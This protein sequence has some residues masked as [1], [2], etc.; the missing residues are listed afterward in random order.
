MA[1]AW[2]SGGSLPVG[3]DDAAGCGVWNAA[4]Q[5][6]GSP[7][8]GT[9][10]VH[11]YDGA[12]WSAKTTMSTMRSSNG[13]CGTTSAAWAFA[14]VYTG[15]FQTSTENFNGTSWSS[16]GS[17]GTATA[18][19]AACGTQTAG[20][21]V[22]GAISGTYTDVT[23]HYNGSTTSTGGTYPQALC[24]VATAG[25]QTAAFATGGVDYSGTRK[26][27]CYTYNGTSWSSSTSLT[28]GRYEHSASGTATGCLAACGIETSSAVSSAL[29][30]NGGSWS[31][32]GNVSTARYKHA[33]AGGTADSSL[34]FG[35]TNGSY[36]SSTEEYNDK[37][38]GAF[39]FE[40]VVD[41]PTVGTSATSNIVTPTDTTVGAAWSVTGGTARVNG[42]AWASSGTINP[43]DTIQLQVTSSSL[44]ATTVSATLT[45]GGVSDT[46]SVTTRN[47]PVPQ[48]MWM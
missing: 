34:I 8:S 48:I 33:G 39:S 4:L 47:A 1:S 15:T 38:P 32:A 6:G 36:L 37:I 11:Q 44:Y 26:T 12:A 3:L 35:G 9:N 23:K 14:G 21:G 7:A 19:P 24:Y 25:T 28:T 31:S 29:R 5:A 30:F 42:G 20:L 27:N 17:Y 45:I 16:G 2:S 13:C 18:S 46:W 22:A 40:D 10:V 41:F 43:G